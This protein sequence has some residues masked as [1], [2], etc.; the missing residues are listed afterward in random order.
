ELGLVQVG[1]DD[2]LLEVV[3]HHITA[4]AAE[5]A[6]SVS[7]A[8]KPKKSGGGK[9]R[10]KLAAEFGGRLWRR[11]LAAESGVHRAPMDRAP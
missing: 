7:G 3:Q 2:T 4:G 5:V 1:F 8:L 6:P 10:R 11:I 9:W